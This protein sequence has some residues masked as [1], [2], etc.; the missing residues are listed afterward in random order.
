MYVVCSHF[1][2]AGHPGIGIAFRN[3]PTVPAHSA[4]AHKCTR[5]ESLLCALPDLVMKNVGSG[6]KTRSEMYKGRI[7]SMQKSSNHPTSKVVS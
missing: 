6:E 1:C 5:L 7:Q 4:S 2:N 3:I